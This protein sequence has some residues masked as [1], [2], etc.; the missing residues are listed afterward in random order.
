MIL[1]HFF[2]WNDYCIFSFIT[3]HYRSKKM[4][5][6]NRK[7][8]SALIAAVM[9]GFGLFTVTSPANAA[10]IKTDIVMLVDESG[11]MSTIHNNL[12][13]S[14]GTFA[15]ILQNGG[16]DAQFALIGYGFAGD[17]IRL[18]SDF[19]DAAGFASAMAGI[20]PVGADEPAY[21]ATAYALEALPS[22]Q[23]GLSYRDDAVKNLILFADE[24]SNSDN[25]FDAD[26]LDGVLKDNSALF[27]VVL[28]GEFGELIDLALNNGGN[29]FDL[30]ELNTPVQSEIDDFV[31]NFAEVKL[32][33]T[34]DFC[35]ENPDHPA[36]TDS[37]PVPAPAGIALLS[38]GLLLLTRK[39]LG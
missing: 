10:L 1:S 32:Q 35:A 26:S 24:A 25:Y 39:K 13:D 7:T 8:W 15:S 5:R 18:L 27:N 37:E 30:N 28:G 6:Q 33:E 38:L 36:C 4:K 2:Q 23:P 16:L 3:T 22:E 31:T 21:D 19:V 34:V 20:T 14:I 12:R 9:L 11:S 29:S 17:S